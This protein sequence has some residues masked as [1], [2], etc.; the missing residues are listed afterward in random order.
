MGF[1]LLRIVSWVEWGRGNLG[2]VERQKR[3]FERGGNLGGSTF[4]LPGLLCREDL[5]ACI[6]AH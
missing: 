4:F 1:L 5:L 2:L 6:S 3:V